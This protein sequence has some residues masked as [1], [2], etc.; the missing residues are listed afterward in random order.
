[1]FGAYQAGAWKVLAE[2]F[3]PDLIVGVSAGALNGWSLAG[4]CS[5]AELCDSWTNPASA[6][7]MHLRFPALPWRGIFDPA[8]FYRRVDEFFARYQPRLPFALTMVEV[9]RVRQ[10]CVPGD[11]VTPAHLRASCA[12][13]FGFPPERIDGKLYVDGG[14]LAVV[15]L[16]AAVE[17]GATSA[18][19][20]NCLPMLPS[21]VLRGAV[22]AFRAVA[23]PRTPVPDLEV[24][25]IRPPGPLGSI[26]DAV[27][28]KAENVERWIA[29]GERD[30]AAVSALPAAN[31]PVPAH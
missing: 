28:W 2:R 6:N 31:P 23:A 15:P 14:L 13:P 9:P 25:E 30:A 5:P 17:M 18:V 10:V 21:R 12:I 19:V 1:M 3:R 11:R 7:L 4:G 27:V 22:K 8:P 16:L 29:Q 24:V 26:R 20:V